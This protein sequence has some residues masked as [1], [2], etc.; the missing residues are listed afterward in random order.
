MPTY[1]VSKYSSMPSGPPSRPS[2][3]AL[4]PPKGRRVGDNALV[5]AHHARFQLLSD[6][7]GPP[8]TLGEGVGN[9][10]ELGVVGQR[11][12]LVIG[13]E[14]NDRRDRSENLL[15]VDPGARRDA[16]QHRRR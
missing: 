11:D 15:A 2:P 4:T 10:A 16:A 13:V 12:A 9:Q 3:D 5:D 1:L 8:Q 6:G 14:G 7:D